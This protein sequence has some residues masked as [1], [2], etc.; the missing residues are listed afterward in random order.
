MAFLFTISDLSLWLAI[1]AIILIVTSEVLYT[2]P[3]VLGRIT[4]NRNR[5]RFAALGC[6][7]AFLVTVMLHIFNIF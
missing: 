1:T 5:F 4:I 6:G 2:L 3:D 7:V